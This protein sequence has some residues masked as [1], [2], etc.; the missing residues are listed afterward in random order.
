MLNTILVPLDGSPLA[1]TALEPALVLARRCEADLLLVHTL[2]PEAP[3]EG[4]PRFATTHDAQRYLKSIADY[5]R[6]EEIVAHTVVLPLEAAEGIVNEAAFSRVDLIVMATHGRKGLDALLHPSVTWQ[7]LRQTNAPI[8]ACKCAQ[9]DDPAALTLHLP[10]FMTDQQAPILV[11]LDGSLQAESALPV[12]QELARTFGNPLLLVRSG[13]QPYIAGGVIGYEAIMGQAWEWSLE[14]AE[15][16]LKR[17]AAGLASTGIRVQTKAAVGGAAL[18]IQQVAQ[19]REGGLIVIA[20]HGRGW[21]GRLVLGSVARRILQEMD[22]PVLLVRRQP[23][24]TEEAQP[25]AT[26]KTKAQQVAIR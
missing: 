21:L 17:K 26:P 22:T 6:S 7:V 14:E 1:E 11:A 19:E 5:L 13:E 16:Y 4:S 8:L 3:P 2:F 18:F 25:A 12:A 15:N 24:P 20:S 10:R 9:D 23:L